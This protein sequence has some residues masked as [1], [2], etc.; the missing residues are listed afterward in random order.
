MLSNHPS[1]RLGIYLV[2]LVS[3]ASSFLVDALIGGDLGQALTQTSGYLMA[4]ALGV[5]AS[6][7]AVNAPTEG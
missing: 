3:G 2:A 7:R 1:L 5:A 4:A 6:A